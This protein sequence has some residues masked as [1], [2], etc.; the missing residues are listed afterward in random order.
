MLG[1]D[2]EEEVVV[3]AVLGQQQAQ[4][5]DEHER[6]ADLDRERAGDPAPPQPRQTVRQRQ[7]VEHQ[8]D[9]SQSDQDHDDGQAHHVPEQQDRREGHG[10]QR[11]DGVKGAAGI[12]GGFYAFGEDPSGL[13]RVDLVGAVR[14]DRG[15]EAVGEPD[16]V[17]D[18]DEAGVHR[19][20]RHDQTG[21]DLTR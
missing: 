11:D 20:E 3:V 9:R 18:P 13:V 4:C 5:G 14:Q 8:R 10:D 1:G 12:D 17:A 21:D 6:L 16:A 15:G 2:A 7:S 19:D